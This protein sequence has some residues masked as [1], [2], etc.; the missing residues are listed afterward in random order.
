MITIAPE[1][2]LEAALRVISEGRKQGI[3]FF[4]GHSAAMDD[5]LTRTIAAGAVGWNH[6]GNAVPATVPKFE[7]VIFHVLAQPGLLAS[8][9][10]DGLH[11]PPHVFC[12]LARVLNE[13][14]P[15]R[16]LLTTD[17]MAGAAA[18]RPGSYTLGEIEVVV[19]DDGSARLPGSKRLSGSTLTPFAGV[20]L[21]EHM[22]GLFLEDVWDAFSVRPAALLQFG[23]GLAEGNFADFC[24]LSPEKTPYLCA[25]YHRGKCVYEA[26]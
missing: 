24:L 26:P 17:A 6:L 8:L 1:V 11:L 15:S 20:F 13:V 3:Q 18:K 16:L 10:P 14:E 12:V 22:S 9:I 21:A 23:H 2:S 19:G 4:L 7:N 5:I 25:T